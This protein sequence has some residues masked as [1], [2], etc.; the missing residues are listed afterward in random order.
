MFDGDDPVIDVVPKE[1]MALLF[2][3]QLRHTGAEVHSGVKYVLRSDVMY[4]L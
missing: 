4:S 1:G 2:L 3:H